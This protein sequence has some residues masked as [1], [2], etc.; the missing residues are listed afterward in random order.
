MSNAFSDIDVTLRD[1]RAV[2]I[3]A[4]STSDEGEILQAFGR[5]DLTNH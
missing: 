4:V 3:G 5:L 1:G 2:R